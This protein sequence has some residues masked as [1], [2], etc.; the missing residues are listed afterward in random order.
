MSC[1]TAARESEN[2]MS[3]YSDFYEPEPPN[4]L[5]S[6]EPVSAQEDF[7]PPPPADADDDNWYG[8][9]RDLAKQSHDERVAKTPDRIAYA[10][11]QFKAAGVEYYLKNASI[12]H[13]HC[14]RKSDGQLFQFWAG[15]GKIMGYDKCRGIHALIKLLTK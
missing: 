5:N 14:C 15:T 3:H 9:Y 2:G 13:F 4:A 7:M 1:T 12:G 8:V 10:E 11:Q 6:Y